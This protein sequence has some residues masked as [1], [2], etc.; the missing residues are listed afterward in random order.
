MIRIGVTESDMA[1][2]T[3]Y[4]IVI[5][6]GLCVL[7]P[8][9]LL[10][11]TAVVAGVRIRREVGSAA[12][13][14]ESPA[15][16]LPAVTLIVPMSQPGTGTIETL[17]TAFR[18]NWR[19]LEI[20]LCVPNMADGAYGVALTLMQKFPGVPCRLLVGREHTS[21]NPKLDN[22]EKCWN[23]VRTEWVIIAD[24]NLQM[25]PDF[26]ERLF[27]AWK[28]GT[29][30]ASS[31]PIGTEPTGFWAQVECA[32]LNTYQARL[33]LA[34]DSLGKGFAHGKAMLFE[35]A[36]LSSHG[37]IRALELDVAEDS[38]ATKIV[39]LAGLRV[40]LVDTPFAQP[41]GQRTFAKVWHRQLRW[42]QLRRQSYPQLFA[43]EPLTTSALPA[44]S[45]AL[46]A[47]AAN[48]Q[49]LLAMAGI[50]ALWL[51][52]E[53]LL[54]RVARMPLSCEYLIACLL[55]DALILAIWPVAWYRRSYKWC[56][57]SISYTLN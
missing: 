13:S 29:G 22:I 27:A 56:G 48:W 28:T 54:A 9:L 23:E 39:R 50:L 57:N 36:L 43:L 3:A 55:R 18:L 7:G 26:V 44:M 52:I 35:K 24:C 16:T 4:P 42:A 12:F 8:T 21:R 30:L 32:F 10:A 41:I 47:L 40:D 20:F 19:N 11:W 31:P 49:P 37:G 5:A 25:P 38:A 34:A 51:A 14:R 15:V 17:A 6:L 2:S 53:G 45:A 46:L 1:G 33:Q